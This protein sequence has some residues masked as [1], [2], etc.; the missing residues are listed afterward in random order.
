MD[1]CQPSLLIRLAN[2][3]PYQQRPSV[4][5]LNVLLYIQEGQVPAHFCLS[6]AQK[7]WTFVLPFATPDSIV[8]IYNILNHL[9][10]VLDQQ[11]PHKQD[12]DQIAYDPSFLYDPVW[13]QQFW[14]R[15]LIL[16]NGSPPSASTINQYKD[17][18]WEAMQPNPLLDIQQSLNSLE[19]CFDT[20]TKHEHALKVLKF[21]L[22]NLTTQELA[23]LHV[24]ENIIGAIDAEY[25][26]V[27]IDIDDN[28][29][30]QNQHP[31]HKQHEAYIPYEQIF[32]LVSDN[33]DSVYNNLADTNL[34]LLEATAHSAL[35]VL[36][37]QGAPRRNEY[38]TL[39][40]DPK[41]NNHFVDDLI[42]LQQYKTA[43]FYGT[44]TFQV[45]HKTKTIL[46]ELIRQKQ[47][48]GIK[49][50]F[51]KD[52]LHNPYHTWTKT[53][54]KHFQ[55]IVGKPLTSR[56]LRKFY[57]THLQ[58]TGRLVYQ[59]QRAELARLMGNRIQEQQSVYTIRL[60]TTQPQTD[61][62]QSSSTPTQTHTQG[63]QPQPQ[64][65]ILSNE[66]QTDRLNTDIHEPRV[67]QSN[68]I[69]DNQSTDL[70]SNSRRGPK[71]S[72]TKQ[73]QSQLIDLIKEIGFD[74]KQIHIISSQRNLEISR[75]SPDRI[76]QKAI[77]LKNK[78]L[79]HNKP[80]G[81]L[82]LVST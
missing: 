45:S 21:W 81:I 40:Y 7:I 62:E 66:Q 26:E 77:Q 29:T 44:Y 14:E 15:P 82:T 63:P 47:T 57:V 19:Q 42:V 37:N 9:L 23:Q 54:E 56:I 18:I 59:Q 72:W 73:E 48:S 10:Q 22:R 4:E 71:I 27:L 41:S 61:N 11:V 55:T 35:L 43:K 17:K 5:I 16:T 24:D 68:P 53:T 67:L 12:V 76:K 46:R 2:A 50:L 39:T 20:L 28:K 80:L 69:P 70:Q 3:I 36:E 8:P 13:I 30:L 38:A 1:I 58:L 32:Q 78:A 65:Q 6:D 52:N 64:I 75:R 60:H 34:E 74:P 25:Q 79:A 51:A 49:S 33:L 31:T